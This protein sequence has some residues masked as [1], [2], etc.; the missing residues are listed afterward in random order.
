[1]EHEENF[2]TQWNETFECP[3]P[4]VNGGYREE[5]K[6]FTAEIDH[7]QII[8]QYPFHIKSCDFWHNDV[9]K[10][11]FIVRV[12]PESYIYFPDDVKKQHSVISTLLTT[13]YSASS[14]EYNLK[15]YYHLLDDNIK[16]KKGFLNLALIYH[17]YIYCGLSTEQKINPEV[18]KKVM[19]GLKECK[20]SYDKI[21][22]VIKAIPIENLKHYLS[23]KKNCL[24]FAEVIFEENE[25]E[26]IVFWNSVK[27]Y[28]YSDSA[29]EHMFEDGLKNFVY[30]EIDIQK[31]H[32]RNVYIYL[33]F[34]RLERRFSSRN[35][36]TSKIKKI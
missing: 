28:L 17:P 8:K 3:P 18:I 27:E 14:S 34:E 6:L 25:F 33:N 19:L 29:F 24:V 12:N 32:I 23:E 20:L 1:M 5:Y 31:N 35:L 30:D 21:F 2:I 9:Q 16:N 10:Q 36:I 11:C 26:S 22:S 7:Y 15:G 4:M 13:N